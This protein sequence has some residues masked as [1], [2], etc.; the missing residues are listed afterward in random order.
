MTIELLCWGLMGTF[1]GSFLNVCAYRLP[2]E[3][4]VV[5][6][7]S[8]CPRCGSPIAWYDNIPLLSFALLR[9]RCRRCRG[10]IH[11]RYP[12]VEALSGIA[13][14]AVV[15][16]FGHGPVALIYLVFIWALLTA[17]V[18][19]FEFQIIPDEIS[20][21]GLALGLLAGATVPALHA[22][23]SI[24]LGLARSLVGVFVGGGTIYAVGMFGS[25]LLKG[26]RLLGVAMRHHPAWRRRLARYRHMREAM[27]GGDVKLMA[28]AGSV[29]GW[30]L[31][32]LSF[33]LAPVLAVV[34]GM[35]WLWWKRSSLI[36][37]GPFLSAALVVSLFAGQE[38][39]QMSGIEDTVTLLW[40]YAQGR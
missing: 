2:R 39:L 10:A 38:L 1:V 29:L 25:V 35:I 27:G 26:L 21:G 19:D 30:K 6:P 7:R 8:R 16:R 12:V 33:F 17:S 20:L 22:T 34:P 18:V 28:M 23:S 3:Q 9:G 36:P 5:R 4:S 40:F 32:L 31:V 24:W 37:Y 11:W 15:H 14:V 13:A